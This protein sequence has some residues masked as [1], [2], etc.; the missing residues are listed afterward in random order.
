M[1]EINRLK[2]LELKKDDLE[3]DI[4]FLN[5]AYKY[6]LQRLEYQLGGIENQLKAQSVRN[7]GGRIG[8]GEISGT[9]TSSQD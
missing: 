6:D 2:E 7:V 3:S 5:S 4:A 9:I 8:D 1:K